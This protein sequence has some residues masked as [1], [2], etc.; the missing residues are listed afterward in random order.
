VYIQPPLAFSVT[1]DKAWLEIQS[2]SPAGEPVFCLRAAAA[3]G[4]VKLRLN[5]LAGVRKGDILLVGAEDPER[6]EYLFA[7]GLEWNEAQAGP[8][9]IL[10][11]K[12]LAFGYPPDTMVRKIAR[13]GQLASAKKI[14]LSED[15]RL[16]DALLFLKELSQPLSRRLAAGGLLWV[17]ERKAAVSLHRALPYRTTSNAQGYFRLPPIGKIAQVEIEARLNEERQVKTIFSPDYRRA[18][19]RVD[20]IF[21]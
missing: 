7:E 18:D 9:V 15:A 19:N 10:L 21:R 13:S 2:V 5:S 12:P 8:G 6:S 3:A 1:K 20:L 14:S 11:A 17:T 16:G 4:A